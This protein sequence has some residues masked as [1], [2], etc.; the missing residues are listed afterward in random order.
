MINNKC[1]IVFLEF[2][3]INNISKIMPQS[4]FEKCYRKLLNVNN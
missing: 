1:D 3:K 2:K 4:C